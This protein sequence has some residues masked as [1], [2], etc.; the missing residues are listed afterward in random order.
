MLPQ[1]FSDFDISSLV[2]TSTEL[3]GLV[4]YEAPDTIQDYDLQLVDLTD[5]NTGS[6]I[7][8]EPNTRYLAVVEYANASANVF[9]AFN[10]DVFYFFPSTF[11]FNTDW[12]VNGFGGDI[13]ALL[14]MYIALEGNTDEQALPE[15][16]LS[17]F[18]NPVVDQLQLNVDFVEATD[19]TITLADLSGRVIR[20]EN[21]EG[22]TNETLRYNLSGFA[23]GTYLVRIA[24]TEGTL[25]KKFV[26]MR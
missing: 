3:L 17:V 23:A 15:N 2:S 18:P 1:I 7:I 9:H 25:T 22:L 13:N 8:L 10:D 24:T 12:N 26:V 4:S 11:V 14:R 5:L 6:S 16:T 21:H 20:I 19:A